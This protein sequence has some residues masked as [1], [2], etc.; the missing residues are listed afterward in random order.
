LKKKKYRIWSSD[1]HTGIIEDLKNLLH[2]IKPIEIEIIDHNLHMAYC[3]FFNS[4]DK[5]VVK[6]GVSMSLRGFNITEL[7]EKFK[8]SEEMKNIDGY[9]SSMPPAQF[10]YYMFFN[11]PLIVVFPMFYWHWREDNINEIININKDVK[12]IYNDKKNFISANN[13]FHQFHTNLFLDINIDYIPSLCNYT[14]QF[15][16]RK[17][18]RKEKI[19]IFSRFAQ[20]PSSLIIKLQERNK[21]QKFPITL[22]F[23]KNYNFDYLTKNVSGFFFLIF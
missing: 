20:P 15:Y 10:Q 18:I 17:K 11:K 14:N 19:F 4:C 21:N 5:I 9:L 2:N 8:D 22:K 1:W 6:R 3:R 7:Y 12:K 13:I 16:D 23:P